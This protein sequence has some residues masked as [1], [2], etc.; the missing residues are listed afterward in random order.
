MHVGALLS[1]ARRG[2]VVLAVSGESRDPT[3]EESQTVKLA[4]TLRRFNF[5]ALQ[6]EFGEDL[7]G[8][9]RAASGSGTGYIRSSPRCL[10]GRCGDK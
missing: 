5:A 4:G 9:A 7:L 8:R 3:L 10:H 1:C 2:R 6:E